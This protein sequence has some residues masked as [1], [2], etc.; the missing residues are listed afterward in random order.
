MKRTANHIYIFHFT[1][2]NYYTC[3]IIFP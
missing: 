1:P 3:L 2:V